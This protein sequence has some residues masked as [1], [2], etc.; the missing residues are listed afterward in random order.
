M[1]RINKNEIDAIK[2]AYNQITE[3]VSID[4]S[5]GTS[6]SNVEGLGGKG[7]PGLGPDGLSNF[8]SKPT[9]TTGKPSSG[10]RKVGHGWMTNKEGWAA[11]TKIIKSEGLKFD[12]N[13]PASAYRA[14]NKAKLYKQQKIADKVADKF[15]MTIDRKTVLSDIEKAF[16]LVDNAKRKWAQKTETIADKINQAKVKTMS[17]LWQN[18]NN[19]TSAAVDAVN[20]WRRQ[21]LGTDAGVGPGVAR[22][23][24]DPPFPPRNW[25][26]KT[27]PPPFTTYSDPM[28]WDPD[29]VKKVHDK[30]LRARKERKIK[31]WLR[32]L[33]K[34][35]LRG[36]GR[37]APPVAIGLET[38]DIIQNIM[39]LYGYPNKPENDPNFGDIDA[40]DH[41]PFDPSGTQGWVGM[42][43]EVHPWGSEHGQSPPDDPQGAQ[44]PNEIPNG[45]ID[46][47]GF[48]WW[49]GV[50]Y[51]IG[52][53]SG[54][55]SDEP[56][57]PVE[58]PRQPTTIRPPVPSKYA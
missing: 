44:A 30:T 57:E 28:D 25:P 17:D 20:K 5:Y 14:L 16:E 45:Y 39:D 19:R 4:N 24:G 2:E 42:D 18:P 52:K 37:V 1:A 46:P 10:N 51:D 47:Y 7:T 6:T 15:G 33:G 43:G 21:K 9:S 34:K 48:G 8:I 22:S 27:P 23:T 29:L 38:T 35:G 12:E 54:P 31:R 40:T 58:V 26:P 50:P 11:L 13:D 32:K 3:K 49:D 53:W 56:D 55:P 41:V 36:F